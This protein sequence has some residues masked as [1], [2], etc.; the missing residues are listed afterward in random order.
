MKIILTNVGC[1]AVA[2][3]GGLAFIYSGIYDV[4]ATPA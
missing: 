1:L 4:S 3:A 2:V